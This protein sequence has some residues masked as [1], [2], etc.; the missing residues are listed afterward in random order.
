VTPPEPYEQAMLDELREMT[1]HG[2]VTAEKIR[3]R[4][5]VGFIK[6]ERLAYLYREQAEVRS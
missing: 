3:R 1:W 4:L 2:P 5:R 6:A